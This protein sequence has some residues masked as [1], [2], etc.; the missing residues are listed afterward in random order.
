MSRYGND[1]YGGWAPYVPVAQRRAN[2]RRDMAKMMK[3]GKK[4]EPI[5]IEGRKIAY[6]FWGKGWC[7]HL[8]AFGDYSNRLPRGRTYAR[9]GSI[10]HLSIQKGKVEAFVSGSSLYRVEV[11]ISPLKASKWKRLKQSCTGKIGSLVELLQG[12]LSEE[13][14]GV[15]TNDKDGLFPQS[16]EINFQ[17]NCPDWADMCKH[18]SAVMYGIG[19][20]LDTQPELLFVL[21]GVDHEELITADAAEQAITGSSSAQKGRRRTIS[22]E[23]LG[24]VF[25]VEL[26]DS[27]TVPKKKAKRKAAKAKKKTTARAKANR[28]KKQEKKQA[29][30]KPTARSITALR[31]R[32]R[33]TK[34]DFAEVIEVSAATVGRWEQS[35]GPLK[36]RAKSVEALTWFH[37]QKD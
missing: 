5:E 10:C 30:F 37:S 31:R 8:E 32:F 24:D 21:R 11:E 9:N 23:A 7:D 27:P 12:R 20:R 3:G 4:A 17:C 19:A 18:I 34:T 33:M 36:I 13:I 25:G 16:G 26:D 28:A 14:M 15:V 6:S 29:P 35:S 2:A 1:H 22:T